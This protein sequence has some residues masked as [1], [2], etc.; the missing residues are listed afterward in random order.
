MDLQEAEWDRQARGY[1]DTEGERICLDCVLDSQL[2]SNLAPGAED[3]GEACA[4]CGRFGETVSGDDVLEQMLDAVHVVYSDALGFMPVEGSH[5]AFDTTDGQDVMDYE[6]SEA[7]AEDAYLALRPYVR[8][9]VSLAKD[10]D[11]SEALGIWWER[12]RDALAASGSATGLDAHFLTS[13]E[14]LL[15]SNRKLLH[16]VRA[17]T[18]YWRVRELDPGTTLSDYEGAGRMGSP[19]SARAKD[20]R[21]SRAGR[22][23]FYGAEAASTAIAEV[24]QGSPG[25]AV[26]ARF[27]TAR[28]LTLLDLV[29]LPAAPSIYDKDQRDLYVTINFLREFAHDVSQPV[30]KVRGGDYKLT[31]TITDVVRSLASPPVDGI[32][33]VSAQ[34]ALP[35][36][37]IFAEPHECADP[38]A[39]TATTMLT[40]DPGSLDSS[41]VL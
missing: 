30:S 34:D 7:L 8:M 2:R 16:A 17:G 23:A 13:L 32:R 10:I 6:F 14:H 18:S 33:Y 29:D 24:F 4:G 39:V 15:A 21:F 27:S 25:S 22:S 19:P 5:F 9:D 31:Q 28:N 11:A 12:L 3:T 40:Y 26:L 35:S 37:I 20:N 1:D 41:P 38:G 36:V